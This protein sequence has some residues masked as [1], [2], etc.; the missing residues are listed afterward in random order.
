MK[1]T[2]SRYERGCSIRRLAEGQP[3]PE[4]ESLEIDRLGLVKEQNSQNL[5]FPFR[6]NKLVMNLSQIRWIY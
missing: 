4:C 1:G 6:I 5:L 3:N 2:V